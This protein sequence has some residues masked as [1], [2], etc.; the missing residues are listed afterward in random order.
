MC[1]LYIEH[2]MEGR[3]NSVVVLDL[4]LH[5]T[6][7]NGGDCGNT[8]LAAAVPCFHCCFSG[9]RC[10]QYTRQKSLVV[11]FTLGLW[12]AFYISSISFHY[13]FHRELN[14]IVFND[15]VIKASLTGH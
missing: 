13:L 15:E 5:F 1:L 6:T 4:L 2:R 10:T 14:I 3:V 12:L 7:D 8:V 11:V 9:K